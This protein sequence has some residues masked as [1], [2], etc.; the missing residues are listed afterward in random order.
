ML[1]KLEEEALRYINVLG[2]YDCDDFKGEQKEKLKEKI[3]EVKKEVEIINCNLVETLKCYENADP[4]KAQEN[5]ELIMDRL[6]DDL[7]VSTMDGWVSID[8]YQTVFHINKADTF[9]EYVGLIE[10]MRIWQIILTSCFIYLC[11]KKHILIMRG[12]V[13]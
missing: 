13:S 5:F 11:P 10:K 7:F 3:S 8:K 4:K 9:F 2:E 6:K 12:L 1:E